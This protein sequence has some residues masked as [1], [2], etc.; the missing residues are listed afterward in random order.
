MSIDGTPYIFPGNTV[1]KDFNKVWHSG[2]IY[3]PDDYRSG[4]NIHKRTA[5]Y[6]G[7]GYKFKQTV[8]LSK[9]ILMVY[10]DYNH[11][12]YRVE[13]GNSPFSDKNNLNSGII[14]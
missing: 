5:D 4:L 1:D 7:I 9:V 13:T 2:S 3:G 8:T 11:Y 10:G 14:F 6:P 12:S